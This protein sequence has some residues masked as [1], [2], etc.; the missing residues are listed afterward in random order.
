MSGRARLIIVLV[1]GVVTAGA[2]WLVGGPDRRPVVETAAGGQVQ[3]AAGSLDDL[4]MDLQLVPLDGRPAKAFTLESL[5]GKRV[6]LAD[7]AGRPA[8][9]YFWATW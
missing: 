5:D 4:L 6:A 8:L 1:V 9:L 2:A 3:A 7:V